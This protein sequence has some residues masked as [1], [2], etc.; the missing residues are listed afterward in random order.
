[1]FDGPSAIPLPLEK[2]TSLEISMKI[3]VPHDDMIGYVFIITF[4]AI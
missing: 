1:V 4:V 3:D 2:L